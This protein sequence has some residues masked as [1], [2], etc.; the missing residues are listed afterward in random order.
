MEN[1][2]DPVEEPE[3][4]T[5]QELFLKL[6]AQPRQVFAYINKHYY[7]KHVAVLLI[8]AGIAR[9]FDR[10][11]TKD[12]GDKY[13]MVTIL[14]MCLLGGGLLGWISFYIY[15]ALVSWTGR[16]LDGEGDTSAILR[17]LAYAIIPNILGLVVFIPQMAIFG[18][19]VF[20]AEGDTFSN[21]VF[22]NLVYTTS[23][24][25]EFGLSLV[26]I[27]FSIIAIST[28][29]GFGIGKA[30]LNALLPVLII[31]VPIASIIVIFNA[32]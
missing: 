14:L 6:W 27:M 18:I 13:S 17:V 22:A 15:A 16:W 26:T 21:D 28:V 12:M 11:V 2:L 31:I 3:T 10:A 5:D 7:D 4:Y 19:E 25:I 30:I 24:I 8:L 29:Q 20:K 1:T 9:A 32:F 23:I